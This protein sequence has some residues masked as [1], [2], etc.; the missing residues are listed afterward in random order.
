MLWP[1]KKRLFWKGYEI[2]VQNIKANWV[3]KIFVACII[4]LYDWSSLQFLMVN[5]LHKP[6]PP[7][8]F[9]LIDHNFFA[10]MMFFVDIQ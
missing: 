7:F 3:K 1:I 6:W 9:I 2:K 8:D 4:V 5:I 10:A